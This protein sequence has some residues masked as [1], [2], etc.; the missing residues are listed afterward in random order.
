MLGATRFAT[1]L[2]ALLSLV[3][4]ELDAG[5]IPRSWGNVE[6]RRN[7]DVSKSYAQ[8]IIDLR[9]RNIDTKPVDEY[10]F[11]LPVEVFEKV[12]LFSA[13]LKGVD[14]FLESALL[15]N[16]NFLA[17]GETM[18]VGI[19]RLP[20]AIAVGQEASIS[21]SLI[22]HANQQPYPGHVE[23]GEKQSLLLRTYKFPISAY[24][25]ESYSLEFQGSSSF[26]ELATEEDNESSGK[27]ST[28]K[29]SFGPFNDIPPYGDFSSVDIL[30]EHNLPLPRVSTLNRSVWVSHWA[31]SLQ[32]EEYYELTNDAAEL[33]SGFSRADYM[34]GQHALKQSGH[35]TAL[36]MILPSGSEGHYCTDLVG[37]VSTFKVLKDHFF[38]KPRYP[39]FG[40]WNYNFTVGWT[41][42]LSQF[43]RTENTDMGTYILSFPVLNGLADTFYDNVEV[44]VYLPEGAKVLDIN[45][46]LPVIRTEITTEKSYFDL[47]E[48]HTKVKLA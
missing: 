29:I 1:V 17:S 18:K 26:T 7:I 25:T 39:L 9:I 16:E 2:L 21:I 44:S 36:E 8:E 12:S 19:I 37:A 6:L 43:L 22:Y 13:S 3:V 34:K 40:S 42:Q 10:Y 24:H 14:A 27:I 32:F 11:V 33:K 31:S 48:G 46:P 47:N 35:L 5:V 38:L 28:S 41:H 30:F 45:C 23:L 20:S 15:P 4:S